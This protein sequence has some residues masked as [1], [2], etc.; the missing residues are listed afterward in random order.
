[1]PSYADATVRQ[2]PEARH[3]HGQLAVGPP[4]R[5]R[6]LHRA[7]GATAA[8]VPRRRRQ[9]TPRPDGH[10]PA[11]A[12]RLEPHA[13]SR[14]T[15]RVKGQGPRR[16]RR[17]SRAARAA[18]H[19]QADRRRRLGSRSSRGWRSPAT[20]ILIRDSGVTID[21]REMHPRTAVGIDQDTG[22]VLMLVIDG[23]QDFSRGYTMVELANC[24]CELGAEDAL[25]LDG[26]GSIDDDG[27]DGRGRARGRSTPRPTASRGR[28][29]TASRSPATYRRSPPRQVS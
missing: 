14:G 11:R 18:R 29:P 23:R 28:S 7:S 20:P 9:Q 25:N 13:G 8:Q 2:R 1:M 24:C 19:G 5:D 6:P 16:P 12:G 21:D 27:P 3:H 15:L 10:G 17:G 22:Q 4:G 26:G